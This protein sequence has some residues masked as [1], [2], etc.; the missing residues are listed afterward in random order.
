MTVL[1]KQATGQLLA[2][3][4]ALK[5]YIDA[6]LDDVA[7]VVTT[8][9]PALQV[10]ERPTIPAGATQVSIEQQPATIVPESTHPPWAEGQFDCVLFKVAG[11][12]TL[13]VPLIEL[14]GIV[15]WNNQVTPLPGHQDWFLGL[16]PVRG[17]QVKVIDMAR[18]VIP[19]RHRAREA[20]APSRAFTHIMLVGNGEWGLACEEMGKVLKLTSDKV[21]WQRDRSQRPWLAGMLIDQMSALLDVERFI[22]LVAPGAVKESRR[23]DDI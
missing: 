10:V 6:L 13:A 11:A 19:E 12:L 18:F 15:K 5:V 7:E 9:A 17:R 16:L 21:R 22:G 20:L 3:D 8:S 1:E 4:L 14:N 2:Q 23:G